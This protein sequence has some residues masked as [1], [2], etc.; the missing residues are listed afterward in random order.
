MRTLSLQTQTN[1][2]KRFH[3]RRKN[4]TI[5]K[6]KLLIIASLKFKKQFIT[7]K[8]NKCA[9]I[10]LMPFLI[11]CFSSCEEV[12]DISLKDSGALLVIEGNIDNQGV[13]EVL[14]SETTSFDFSGARVPVSGAIVKIQE[15]NKTPMVLNE[16]ESGRYILNNFRGKPGSTYYLNVS[17]NG[18]D[19]ESTS[20]MPH[21]VELDSV[22]TIAANVFS[23][24]IKSVAVIYRDPIDVENYYRFKVRINGVQNTTYWVFN[25]RFTN[26]NSVTQTLRDLSN[27]L[28][29][30]DLVTVEMQCI[31]SEVY[32]YWNTLKNQDPGAS[33]PSNP[34]SNIS[35]GALGYF[36]AHTIS[37]ANFQVK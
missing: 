10:I 37:L 18:T 6:N 19:Y 27:K 1:I 31:D 12:I 15:D 34:V 32:N 4:M 5:L 29:S 30:G 17:V 36:S 26:G 25:D 8:S 28:Y 7:M 23:E 14:L 16:Q 2:A 11:F 35:N 20:V 13:S 33:V 21:L 22:G 3:E 9:F 24:T